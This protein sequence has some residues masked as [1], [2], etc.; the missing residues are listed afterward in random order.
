MKHTGKLLNWV[1]SILM[2]C[3]ECFWTNLR[4]CLKSFN[5]LVFKNTCVSTPSR[6]RLRLRLRYRRHIEYR[7]HYRVKFCYQLSHMDEKIACIN[8]IMKNWTYIKYP[9][10][11]SFLLK[12][13]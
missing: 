10:N 12:K 9:L 4:T 1:G 3:K 7:K 2:I 11:L 5:K 13:S 8:L 6:K